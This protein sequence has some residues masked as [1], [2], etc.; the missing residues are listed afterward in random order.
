MRD[1][2]RERKAKVNSLVHGAPLKLKT[3]APVKEA[4]AVS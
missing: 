4:G 1:E 3:P 2:V